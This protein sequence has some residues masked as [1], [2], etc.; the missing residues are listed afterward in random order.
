MEPDVKKAFLSMLLLPVAYAI[1]FWAILYSI[2]NDTYYIAIA[3]VAFAMVIVVLVFRYFISKTILKGKVPYSSVKNLKPTD[4]LCEKE[5]RDLNI[6]I[7]GYAARIKFSLTVD[8]VEIATAGAGERLRIP[9]TTGAHTLRVKSGTSVEKTIPAGSDVD[10][11]VWCDNNVKNSKNVIQIDDVTGGIGALESRDA[12]AYAKTEKTL[13]TT[14]IV[15]GI[16]ST[17]MLAAV[18]I[19]L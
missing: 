4:P 5:K 7:S 15:M 9:V 14:P 11:Y 13:K 10:I 3:A 16:L 12:A 19:F 18:I 6:T 8:D 1:M 2:D 17:V